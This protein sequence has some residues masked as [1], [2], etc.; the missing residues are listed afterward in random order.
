MMDESKLRL[1]PSGNAIL[2][3]VREDYPFLNDLTKFKVKLKKNQQLIAA[4]RKTEYLYF[5]IDALVSLRC[6][7]LSGYT[8]EFSQI[9]RDG[10]VGFTAL[11][12]DDPAPS[13]AVTLTSGN[14]YRIDTFLIRKVFDGSATFR[15]AILSYMKGHMQE[16]AQR[17]VCN[18]YHSI[19]QQ[20]CRTLLMA[21]DRLGSATISLTHEQLAFSIGCRREAVSIAAGKLQTSGIIRYAYGRITILDRAAL[22]NCSCECYTVIRQGFAEFLK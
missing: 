11:I 4:D 12:S 13:D 6:D 21:S 15:R 8:A 16:S 19:V 3:V 2:D 17:I 18:R 9:G 1:P 20:I 22:E 14:A 7:I 5:P 10:I